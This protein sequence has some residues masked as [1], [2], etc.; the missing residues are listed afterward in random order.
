MKKIKLLLITSLM[1]FVLFE[2]QG[3][4][5]KG[6]VNL[7]ANAFL[8]SLTG[9]GSENINGTVI[10]NYQ[11]YIS[12]NVSL[13]FGPLYSWSA[14]STNWSSNFGLNLFLN[15]SFLSSNGKSLPYLGAQYSGTI[16]YSEF[17]SGGGGGSFYSTSQS[18]SVGANAGVKYFFSEYANFDVNLSY[19]SVIATSVDMGN[20]FVD[21]D[22]QGG[23]LQLTLGVGVIIGKKGT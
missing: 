12:D 9:L 21:V 4:V 13:G 18:G 16:N 22:P 6:D 20:G 2:T 14:S 3:Q 1:S 23:F 8:T 11:K 7:G 17:D 10:I 19:T 15:Y 5:Q